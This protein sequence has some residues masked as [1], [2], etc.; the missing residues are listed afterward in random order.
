MTNPVY[1]Y[2]YEEFA[3]KHCG[4]NKFNLS[5]FDKIQ[6]CTFT[7][8]WKPPINS[9]YRCPAHNLAVGSKA[10]EHPAGRAVDFGVTEGPNRL[11][12]VLRLMG[13][14]FRRIGIASNFVHVD[15]YD[16][17]ESLWVYKTKS[18]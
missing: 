14:G 17:I 3:C 7:M 16:A 1:K 5:M 18:P 6:D 15:C 4:L 2:K 11:E 12:L 13:A 9:G 8:Y 10:P